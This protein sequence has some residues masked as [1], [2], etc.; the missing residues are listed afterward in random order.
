MRREGGVFERVRRVWRG[1]GKVFY[2]SIKIVDYLFGDW[3]VAY[4]LYSI[5]CAIIAD[6]ISLIP[7]LAARSAGMAG[8]CLFLLYQQLPGHQGI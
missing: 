4:Y 3:G 8:G 2:K 6:L 1:C 7:W 5:K